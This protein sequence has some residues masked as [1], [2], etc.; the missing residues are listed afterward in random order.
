MQREP[1]PPTFGD[2]PLEDDQV[3]ASSV[4][5][6]GSV[7]GG[8][9]LAAAVASLPAEL[10]L[11]EAHSFLGAIG[12]WLA[13]IAILT[14]LS[15]LAVAVL[16]RA[17]TGLRLLVGGQTLLFAAAVL[18]WAVLELGILSIFGAVLRAKTHHHGLAGVTFAILALISGLMVA[19]LAV[20]GVRMLSRLPVGSH[21]V[22]LLIV[23]AAAFLVVALI[24]VRT[25]RAVGLHTASALV[26]SIALLGATTIASSRAVARG[27]RLAVAGVPIAAA[28][29][30]LGFACL[31]A[32]PELNE[33]LAQGA[34]LQSWLLGLLGP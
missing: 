4:A 17:R 11:G 24:G 20:R 26:D 18:W 27:R 9:V 25:S 21:R 33:L 14:P 16:R 34:P 13:L 15:V 32:E 29:M 12:Q 3:A 10:R 28:V 8:G 19:L 7:V 22:A 31:R 2:E 6:F 1:H 5:R 30:L 23:S